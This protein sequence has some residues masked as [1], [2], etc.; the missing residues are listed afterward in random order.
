MSK[1]KNQGTWWQTNFEQRLQARGLD[2]EVLAERG[3]NDLGD[4]IV[5]NVFGQGEPIIAVAYRRLTKQG[6]KRRKPLGEKEVV[7][8]TAEDF[9]DLLEA[10]RLS[11]IIECK[12]AQQISVTKVLKEA[13]E[14]VKRNATG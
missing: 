14:K 3:S 13:R 2:A 8:V 12:A 4:I 5:R 6:G 11:A 1:N 9:L 7:V 10:S